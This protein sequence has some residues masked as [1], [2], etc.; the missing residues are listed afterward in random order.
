MTKQDGVIIIRKK[1]IIDYDAKLKS[2]ASISGYVCDIP[3]E[4]MI[5]AKFVREF[6]HDFG[7]NDVTMPVKVRYN[8]PATIVWWEDG[9]KTV[10]KLSEGDEP[11]AEKAFL[12][13]F[14]QK[15]SNLSRTQA[16]K[17]LQQ[18]IGGQFNG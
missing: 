17:M 12:S 6:S 9:E 16:N 3:T 1:D 11:D 7:V 2:V 4:F 15:N 18:I 8:G 14:F 10:V 5:R 13:A